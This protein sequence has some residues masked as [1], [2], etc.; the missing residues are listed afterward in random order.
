MVVLLLGQKKT[1]PKVNIL[2]QTSL[3]IQITLYSENLIVDQNYRIQILSDR[4]MAT[5]MFM[6]ADHHLK[7]HQIE[8]WNLE[9]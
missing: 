9:F 4:K 8:N 7:L 6:D 3:S 1:I 5:N 2:Q